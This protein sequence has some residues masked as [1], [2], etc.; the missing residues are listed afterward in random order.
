MYVGIGAGVLVCIGAAV[1]GA[2]YMRAR[3]TEPSFDD[4]NGKNMKAFVCRYVSW[5]STLGLT[6]YQ[7]FSLL[8]FVCIPDRLLRGS[9]NHNNVFSAREMPQ[10]VVQSCTTV[11][12]TTEHTAG[13]GS[14]HNSFSSKRI[15]SK[16]VAFF[17]FH[18]T[19]YRSKSCLRTRSKKQNS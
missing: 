3:N 16:T 9:I 2:M 7:L 10:S 15:A 4:A 5:V 17:S 13:L 6:L 14:S 12:K 8:F 19:L 18:T 1:A 11:I